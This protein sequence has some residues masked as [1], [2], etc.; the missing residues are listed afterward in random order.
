MKPLVL[1]VLFVLT[2]LV[3]CTGDL[4][5]PWQLDHD[6]I[7]AVR[8]TPPR[9][10]AEATAQLDVLIANEG[11]R[12]RTVAPDS[13]D[14]VA[15][16]SLASVVAGDIVTAPSE[17][18]LAAARTELGL[19]ASAPVPLTL[20]VTANG[21]V[22]T[23]TMWLGEAADNPPLTG[24]EI[25]GAAPGD[26]LVLPAKTDIPLAV[27]ADDSVHNVTW[28]T[29]CGTMHDF[30]LSRAYLRIDPDDSQQ[31]ELAVVLRDL[32]GGVSWR[33]WPVRAGSE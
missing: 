22:S 25:D 7:I 29:S 21:F 17:T 10:P 13:I 26:D 20:S 27:T 33:V 9:I 8:A 28:L 19:A 1:F 5:D 15:P 12:T 6:R 32:R 2:S 16:S 3:G 18:M 31:G 11:E 23:T 14:V 30:D 4:V 24:M